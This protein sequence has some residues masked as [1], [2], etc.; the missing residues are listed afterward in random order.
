MNLIGRLNLKNVPQQSGISD[1]DWLTKKYEIIPKCLGE[2]TAAR[3]TMR[4]D[5]RRRAELFSYGGQS[6][7][8]GLHHV[9]LQQLAV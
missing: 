7:P 4:K 8:L 3:K 9:I 6:S 2:K 1:D 5:L